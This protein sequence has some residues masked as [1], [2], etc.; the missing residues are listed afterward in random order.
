MQAPHLLLTLLAR[1]LMR[2]LVTRMY[3]PDD[4]AHATD[5][6]LGLVEPAR[7]ETLV[8]RRVPAR[9]SDLEWN[10]RLQGPGETVFF[11]C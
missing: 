6:A 8:A 5:F 10:L 4:P 2:R 3:F 7:R 11:D 9:P 1:G